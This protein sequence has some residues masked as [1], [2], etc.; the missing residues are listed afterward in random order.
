M[1]ALE[2]IVGIKYD[3]DSQF[4]DMSNVSFLQQKRKLQ[5]SPEQCSDFYADQY[6]KDFFSSL[7]AFMSS[8]PIIAMTLARSDA[9]THWKFVIGPVNSI[10][11]RETHPERS[12]CSLKILCFCSSYEV[13]V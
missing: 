5:L 3:T 2:I 1:A 6:G 9:I 8:G 13:W 4:L 11:A 7:T 10:R 12:V